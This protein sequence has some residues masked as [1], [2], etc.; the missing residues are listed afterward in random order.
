MAA[1]GW[2][3][4]HVHLGR[5]FREEYPSHTPLT[6]HQLIDRMNREGIEMAVLLSLE[7]PEGLW[8]Y[9][10]TEDT[11]A[12][13]D[14]YPERLI[15]FAAVDPRYP[16]SAQ[17]LDHAI[18]NLGCQGVGEHVCGLAL[19]DELCKVLYRKCDEY[20]VPI[21]VEIAEDL[22]WDEAGLP[23]LEACLR[24]FPDAQWV[25]HGPAFWSAISADDPRSGYPTGPVKPGG[26]LDRLLEEY[27]NLYADISAGS[28]YNAMTRDPEFTAGFIERH[29]RKLLFGTDYLSPGD[30]LPVISWLREV[31][32]PESIRQAIGGENARGLLG[33]G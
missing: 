18:R 32:L 7:S 24:E 28:G 16:M 12:A 8:G 19:D 33:I 21:V 23:R 4:F 13:R 2:I 20:G 30:E 10:L 27:D 1:H 3:D 14:L 15:A 31:P 17:F 6:A 5:L 29:W 9:A 11:V 22:C 25:G 26:A